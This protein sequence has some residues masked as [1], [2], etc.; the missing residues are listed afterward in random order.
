MPISADVLP[1]TDIEQ[2]M[3]DFV[4]IQLQQYR[5]SYD[6]SPVSI[7]VVLIGNDDGNAYTDANSWSP[8]DESR[9]RL[10]CCSVASAV[11][12]KRALGL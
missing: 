12:W 7:A 10:H 2:E 1:R 11:L 8:G 4:A 3:L 6:C 9:S 5:E